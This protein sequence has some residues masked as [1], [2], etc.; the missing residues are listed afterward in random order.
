[1]RKCG[2]GICDQVRLKPACSATERRAQPLCGRVLYLGLRGGLFNTQVRL[3][4]AC[5]ASERG[6]QRLSGR[7]LYLGLRCWLFNAQRSISPQHEHAIDWD[8]K[9]QT[10]QKKIGDTLCCVLIKARHFILSL[11]LVQP[12]KT[13]KCLNMTEKLLIGT[14]IKFALKST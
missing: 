9:P 14:E 2:L 4:P 6:A 7:V 11:V 10:K 8:L 3:K 13:G 12:M 1:M 5:S